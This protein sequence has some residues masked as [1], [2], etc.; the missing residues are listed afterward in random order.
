M[1]ATPLFYIEREPWS[2]ASILKKVNNGVYICT[3]SVRS[4]EYMCNTKYLVAYNSKFKPL[5]K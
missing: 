3:R 2:V 1:N 5:H 4:D